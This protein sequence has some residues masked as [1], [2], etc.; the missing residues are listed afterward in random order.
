MDG[1]AANG[2]AFNETVVVLVHFSGL[3]DPR[4][5]GE[6]S[7][8]L[9]EVVLL[10][11]LAVLAGAECFTEIALFGAK[12]LDLPRRFRPFQGRHART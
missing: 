3:L 5:P 6:V 11:L 1:R 10:C 2:A 8:P 12:K 7:Y 9:D 4:Q